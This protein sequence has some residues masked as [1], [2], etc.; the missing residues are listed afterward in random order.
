MD[1]IKKYGLK[2]T[3][4]SQADYEDY[5]RVCDAIIALG[6]KATVVD[7]GNTVFEPIGTVAK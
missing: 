6:F 4:I 5:R 7:N 1:E 2:L 3:I